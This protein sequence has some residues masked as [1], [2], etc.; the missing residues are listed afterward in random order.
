[1]LIFELPQRLLLLRQIALQQIALIFE[2]LLRP[3][4]PMDPQMIFAGRHKQRIEHV[5]SKL[6]V[7]GFIG[8]RKHIRFLPR[9]N[10]QVLLQCLDCLI[11][12]L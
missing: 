7:F 8:D 10:S 12:E 6:R 2:K 1:M 9:R 3:A 5:V 4:G 11:A